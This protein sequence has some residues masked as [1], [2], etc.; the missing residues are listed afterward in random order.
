[1]LN[2]IFYILSFLFLSSCI[3]HLDEAEFIYN[4]A[5][6]Q[7]SEELL[8]DAILEANMI[9]DHHEHYDDALA[10]KLRVDS[11][12]SLWDELE[13]EN[14]KRI[15]DSL[16]HIE[17]SLRRLDFINYP[18]MIGKW[19]CYQTNYLST[20]NSTIRIYKKGNIYYQ[21]MVFDKNGSE[22][23]L[24]LKKKSDK[25]YDVVGKS[26][27][28]VINSDGDLEFWDKEGYFLTSKKFKLKY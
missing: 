7:K 9:R 12:I 6:E 3:N 22:S 14:L 27:Y 4:Q 13:K 24:R 17:D 2:K 26:D 11:V 18:N 15:A 21:S 1:M 10:F 28:N 5:V 19:I 23:V 25:R 20:L 16:H 8:N